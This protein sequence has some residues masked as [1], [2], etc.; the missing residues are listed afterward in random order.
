M[1]LLID[2]LHPAHVH[3]FRNLAHELTERGHQVRFTLREKLKQL[4]LHRGEG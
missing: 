4:G 3:V 2:I 1:R